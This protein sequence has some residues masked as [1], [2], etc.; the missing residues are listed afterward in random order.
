MSLLEKLLLP[1]IRELIHNEDF[2]TLRETFERWEAADI[3]DLLAD[4]NTQEDIAAFQCL[5]PSLGAKTFAYLDRTTQEGLIGVLPEGELARILNE[6]A[7]DDR[8]ALLEGFTASEVERLLTLL[9]PE[10]QRI[11]RSLLSHGEGTVG[12]LMTPDLLT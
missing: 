10:Q 6:I 11:S 12:R 4:L 1:E 3:A 5:S 8:T 9:S 7:P 2:D